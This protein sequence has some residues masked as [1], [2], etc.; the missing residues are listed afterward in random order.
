MNKIDASHYIVL[1]QRIRAHVNETKHI[2][3]QLVNSFEKSPS[4][5]PEVYS[6]NQETEDTRKNAARKMY[7]NVS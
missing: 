6:E 7:R 3:T 4:D 2:M 1:V 5:I